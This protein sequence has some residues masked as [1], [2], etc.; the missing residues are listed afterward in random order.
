MKTTLC[1]AVAATFC[2]LGC[3][4]SS[5]SGEESSANLLASP[6]MADHPTNQLFSSGTGLKFQV[7]K[8][9]D[10]KISPNI[11]DKVKATYTCK[12][13]DGTLV[14]SSDRRGGPVT[15]R[16]SDVVPGWTEGIRLMKVGDDFKFVLPPE[17]GYGSNPPPGSG[18]PPDSTL[19]CEIVLLE[20]E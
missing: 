12:L 18:I 15:F 5:P 4:K 10:G 8:R 1:V 7:L 3:S 20:I 2:L 9:G 17:L 16:L 19:V 13:L 6:A 11:T 14:D